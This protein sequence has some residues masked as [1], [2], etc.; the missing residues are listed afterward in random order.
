MTAS[1]RTILL[2]LAAVPLPATAGGS[3]PDAELLATGLCLLH[4]LDEAEVAQEAYLEA[5]RII[6][7]TVG[8][9]PEQ[10]QSRQ[11][12]PT[13]MAYYDAKSRWEEQFKNFCNR[14]IEAEKLARLSDHDDAWAAFEN[15][16]EKA[17]AAFAAMRATSLDGLILKARAAEREICADWDAWDDLR[18]S[19]VTDLLAMGGEA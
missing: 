6:E 10:P 9:A 18:R 1:R 11:S 12:H 4:L 2:G 7:D 16:L 5:E 3:H 14:R 19:I 15:R 8:K 13:D 17:C